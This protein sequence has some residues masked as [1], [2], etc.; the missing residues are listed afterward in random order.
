MLY[1]AKEDSFLLKKYVEKSAK[2]KVLEIGVG[3]G[4]LMEAALENTKDVEGIDIDREAV[5]FCR[6]KGLNV[7]KGD[8][9][10]DVFRKYDL[11]VFNPPYLPNEKLLDKEKN[12]DLFGGKNGW[13]LIERF[14]NE[15]GRFLE[16]K[17]DILIVF[18]SLTNKNKV[19][20]IIKKNKF[21]VEEL[22]EKKVGLMEK[23]FVYRC[24]R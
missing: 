17:G 16:E 14:F 22:E 18:S 6:K 5:E 8:L 13:E 1:E 2:G 15:V 24:Y 7:K 3:S 21:K 10:D 19:D 9:F 12:R 20:G 23:L 4:I 11:I